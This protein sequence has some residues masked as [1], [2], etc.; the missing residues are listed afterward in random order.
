MLPDSHQ[1]DGAGLMFRQTEGK[2]NRK[3]HPFQP[4]VY[5]EIT[6]DWYTD[7][8]QTEQVFITRGFGVFNMY[9]CCVEVSLHAD[10]SNPGNE[11]DFTGFGH[12]RLRSPETARVCSKKLM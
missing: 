5:L 10:G 2:K 1:L 9:F 4:T 12:P 3:T 7:I 8:P 11:L 6:A